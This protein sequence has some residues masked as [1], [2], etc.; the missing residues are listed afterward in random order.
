MWSSSPLGHVHQRM[1]LSV[2]RLGKSYRKCVLLIEQAITT[3]DIDKQC[4]YA[5]KTVSVSRFL[6]KVNFR[7]LKNSAKIVLEKCSILMLRGIVRYPYKPIY[8]HTI[9]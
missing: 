2:F 1:C 9:K 3:L 4:W 7:A 5:A 6:V 8:L